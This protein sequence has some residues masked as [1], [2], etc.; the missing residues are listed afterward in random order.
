MT[1]KEIL[2]ELGS[3]ER[4]ALVRCDAGLPFDHQDIRAISKEL[5]KFEL[6]GKN[7]WHCTKL[8]REVVAKMCGVEPKKRA[9]PSRKVR[10]SGDAIPA[11]AQRDALC[12]GC[13]KGIPKGEPCIWVKGEGVYHENCVTEQ[14]S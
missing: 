1:V 2:A 12:T 6:I 5:R 8:G 4:I 7:G 10:A 11:M 14:A 3:N 13:T 9:A